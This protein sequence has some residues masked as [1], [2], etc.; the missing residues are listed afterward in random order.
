LVFHPKF[1]VQVFLNYPA[2]RPRIKASCTKSGSKYKRGGTSSKPYVATRLQARAVVAAHALAPQ[3]LA[4]RGQLHAWSH[5]TGHDPNNVALLSF[6]IDCTRS[7]GYFQE[8]A[9]PPP[10]TPRR[11]PFVQN[12]NQYRGG[13]HPSEGYFSY[14]Y[15]NRL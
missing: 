14:Q 12:F 13:G 7:I 6:G 1:V 9:G 4:G 5:L 11:S 15:A 3:N 8:G 10:S 2:N